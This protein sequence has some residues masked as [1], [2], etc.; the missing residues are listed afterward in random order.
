MRHRAMAGIFGCQLGNFVT[1]VILK[2]SIT[3]LEA[4]SSGIGQV[5]RQNGN[6]MVCRIKSGTDDIQHGILT[7]ERV[8]R[9]ALSNSVPKYH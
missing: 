2:H 4:S 7:S 1:I 8:L 9:L 5:M 6:L 3:A